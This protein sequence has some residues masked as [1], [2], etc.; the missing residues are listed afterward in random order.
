MTNWDP[1]TIDEQLRRVPVPPE[2]LARLREIAAYSDRELDH[3]LGDV[4]APAGVMNRLRKIGTLLDTDLDGEMRHVGVPAGVLLRLRRTVRRQILR[5]RLVQLAVAASLVF[6]V[7]GVYWI[8]AEPQHG[9]NPG[10]GALAGKPADHHNGQRPKNDITPP[11]GPDK[12]VPINRIVDIK[13]N[14]LP[15]KTP[16]DEHLSNKPDPTIAVNPPPKHP[17]PVPSALMGEGVLTAL[18]AQE[19][20][21]FVALGL[22]P[23]GIAPPRVKGFDWPLLLNKGVLPFVEPSRS[24][25]LRESRVPI[26]TDTASFD[27]ADRMLQGRHAPPAS[28]LTKIHVEDFLAAMDYGFPAPAGELGVRTAAGQDPWGQGN[29]GLMQV[30]VQA[31]AFHRGLDFGTHLTLCIDASS[32]MGAAGRWEAVRAALVEL[33]A[34]LDPLDRVSVVLFNDQATEKARQADRKALAEIA[35]NLDSVEPHGLG[36]LDAALAAAVKLAR[37]DSIVAADGFSI[38]PDAIGK[39]RGARLLLITSGSLHLDDAAAGRVK[40][41][42]TNAV[43]ARI[44]FQT[45]CVRS[46]GVADTQL[47]SFAAIGG[48]SIGHVATL[49]DLTWQ[50]RDA[51]VGRLEVVASRVSMKVTFTDA[52][53]SYRLIGHEPTVGGLSSG[54]LEAELRTGEAATALY[55]VELKPDGGDMVATVDVQWSEPGA[56]TEVHHLRQAVSRQQFA[57]SW[58]ET[59]LSLQMAT[60][61]AETAEVLRG[62]FFAAQGPHALDGVAELAQRANPA[63]QTR[64]SF[65]QLKSLVDRARALHITSA[66]SHTS[67]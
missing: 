50:L 54:P 7:V 58:S 67:G 44:G 42:L 2:A 66:S 48:R 33:A 20:E 5:P 35:G 29:I 63:L 60:I 15:D 53:A 34:Q 28:D 17:T 43:G 1:N 18:P 55:Q 56:S 13:N 4:P 61:A 47:E 25:A 30:G 8:N 64:P 45:L 21:F 62:S 3:S 59:P 31:G 40:V 39:K 10:N 51:A 41:L 49:H 16:T 14:N 38:P 65:V 26:W 36:N 11:I 32:A 24:P 57:P 27:L 12:H 52:V 22:T 19:A 37:Q 6:V 46:G 9:A 23:R